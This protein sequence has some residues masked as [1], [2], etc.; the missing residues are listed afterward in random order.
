MRKYILGIIFGICLTACQGDYS[1]SKES[2]ASF[3]MAEDF[4]VE[5]ESD[6]S[7]NWDMRKKSTT[8]PPTK[9]PEADQAIRNSIKKGSK[10]IKDGN[11][12]VEVSDLKTAKAQI[13]STL[14]QFD[15]YYENEGYQSGN[16]QSS[17]QL[18]IRVPTANFEKLL[19]AIET[20][21]GKIVQKNISARD[22][23]EEYVDVSIRLNNNKNYL[24]RYQELLKKANSIKDIL[25]IQEKSRRIEEEIDA[26]TGRLKYID[27]QVKFS[28]LRLALTQE[29]EYT[30]TRKA[31]NFGQQLVDSFKNG[32]DGFLDFMLF[33]V[34][35]W[36]F[37]LILGLLWW[38]RGRIRWRFWRKNT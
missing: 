36:P 32:V 38:F 3:E 35:I 37:M 21:N 23:T 18:R 13:D 15:G 30:A 16:Y 12:Q 1:A 11:V 25:E 29:H 28:T 4:E 31:R 19:Q 33:L 6:G 10:I 24:N 8:P 20:G 7:G 5:E 22:V 14:K 34:S 27:D 2:P 26:R 17:Y 9:E